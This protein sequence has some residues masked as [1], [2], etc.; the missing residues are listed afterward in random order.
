[1]E[2]FDRKDVRFLLVCLLAIAAGAAITAAL[3][4]R[5]FPEASIEFKV[6]R[7]Q[8]RAQAESFLKGRGREISGH[9]FAAR[10]D[11]DDEP[12][13]YLER[14]L[15]LERAGEFYGDEAKVWTWQ[16]RWFRSGVK[17]EERVALTPKGDLV[18]FAA[19]L[20]E[21]AP[22]ARL[23]REQARDIASRFLDSRR[24]EPASLSPIE[25]TPVSR[26]KRTD[27]IFVDEKTGLRMNEATVRFETTVS[28]DRVTA[29]R[30]FV[31]VPEAWQR[32]YQRLRSK[33]EA[34]GAVAT[35]GFVLTVLAMLAVLVTKIVRKD[36]PWRLVAAFGGIAFVLTLLSSLNALPLTLFD[37]RTQDPLSSHL[38]SQIVLAILGALALGALIAIIVAGSEP[39][40]RERFPRHLSLAGM[41]SPR[42]VSTKSFF[43]GVLLGYA[44]TAFFFAYQ[45]VFYVVAASLGA[46]APADIPYSDMLNTALPWATVLFIG[47][48]PA[49]SEEG[50]SRMFSISFLE[51]LKVGRILAVVIP[52][53]IWGFGHAAYPN[54]PFYIRGVEVGLAGVLIGFLMIRYGV[55]PLLVWHFTVD[56]LY[57]AL[58]M[59]RSGNTY[60]VV[61]GSVASGVLLLPLAVSLLLYLRRG[62][63]APVSGL[64]NGDEGFVPAP[65]PPPPVAEEV[66]AVRTVPRM[67]FAALGAAAFLLAVSF[68]FPT[69]PR[70]PLAEDATGRARAEN[71][72][73][74]FLRANGV[75]PDRFQVVSY[76][77]T[78]FPDDEAVRSAKPAEEGGIPGFSEGAARYVLQ[79]GGLPAFTKLSREKL[80]LAYW[81]VRFLE[82]GKKEEWKVLVDAGRARVVGFLNPKEEKAEA[83]AAVSSERARQ[84]ALAAARALGFP[85]A[86]YSVLEE[87]TEARPNRTDTTV[88]LESRPAGAGDA[89]PRLTAVFHGARL[90][91]FYPSVRVPEDF[92][93][94]YRKRE[95]LDWFL[96]AAKVVAIG[97]L[98]GIGIVLFLRIVKRP[99]FRWK[100]LVKPL[101]FAALVAALAMANTAP[102]AFQRYQTEIALSVFQLTSAVG[103][104]IGWLG[105]LVGAGIG[106]VLFFA[107]RP[108]WR[109]A[110]RRGSLPDAFARAGI[111]A[112]GLAGLS[113]WV[114]VA[115]A[116]FPALFEPD[117]ALPEALEAVVPGFAVFWSALLAT[118]TLSALLA[119]IALAAA[120]PFFR[121]P[122]ILALSLPALFFIVAPTT[123]RS[124][125]QF[126]ADFVPGLLVTAWIALC[127]FLL[128]RDHVAA[129]VLFGAFSYGGRAIVELLAQPAA[130]DRVAGWTAL[131]L[132]AL[133]AAALLIGRRR[134]TRVPGVPE[135]AG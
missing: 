99:D 121:K 108:G 88:V 123:F 97:A 13:V 10:F 116:R 22:G 106:F 93:R 75:S 31:H 61:S 25:T 87:G 68:L 124:P 17:E 81:V 89:R 120:Q 46:W 21:D 37:Y 84:R 76:V 28:G 33:N 71:L 79:H 3:F 74:R 58:L 39:P 94:R 126:L 50:I 112:L 83:A 12:K 90:A 69:H 60:Y 105:L 134:E 11:V 127:A 2:K 92:L 36:V 95:V 29:F 128:L 72:G 56:A 129:W 1:M 125:E 82:P 67:A 103:L 20:R 114:N 26:P 16:M 98:V 5:A 101:L 59:L 65:P 85:A 41:F 38:T 102:S 19:V 52:A 135:T 30:E 73:R 42:G 53:V 6:N 78:G 57:T 115:S 14:E 70:E 133:G 54:Q 80:P 55:L 110:L 34:A 122:A 62:G 35:F 32:D 111:A 117:P 45:A 107:A 132:I 23:T 48:F 4:R 100:S 96:I 63:F 77:G 118:F 24:L 8:A 27:W 47:F 91:A 49:V 119:V 109:R 131:L 51:K 66:P 86:E 15:G 44:L 9:R 130:L 113:R 43:K 104:L 7:G 40:Y 64:T 18:S